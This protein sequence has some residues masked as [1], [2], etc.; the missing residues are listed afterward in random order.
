MPDIEYVCLRC[1][2]LTDLVEQC[3]VDMEPYG[4][5]RVERVTYEI[6]SSCCNDDVE[7]VETDN[8]TVH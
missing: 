3:T 6:V 2:K 5:Q 7:R 1:R 4:D 8:Y